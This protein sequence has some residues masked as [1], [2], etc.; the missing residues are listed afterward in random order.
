MHGV[1]NETR[2]GFLPFCVFSPER[3]L[4]DLDSML[5]SI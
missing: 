5:H 1:V 2:P 4:H 3:V